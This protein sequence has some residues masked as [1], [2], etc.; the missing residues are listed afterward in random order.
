MWD[1]L[2]N[3]DTEL[4]VQIKNMENMG[5]M[6]AASPRAAAQN[7]VGSVYVLH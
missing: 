3:W 2:M 5:K 7:L 4:Q 1:N 6:D